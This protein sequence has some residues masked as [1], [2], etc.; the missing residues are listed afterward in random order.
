[1]NYTK[2]SLQIIALFAVAI[3]MSFIPDY[4]HEFFGD[5]ECQGKVF[6]DKIIGGYIVYD[7][8]DYGSMNSHNPTLHWGWRHWLWFIMGAVLFIIQCFRIESTINTESK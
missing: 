6:T 1:M 4:L 3:I 8:C 2:L 7:G 5:W